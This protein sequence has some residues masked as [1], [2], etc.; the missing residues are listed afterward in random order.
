MYDILYVNGNR[1]SI[2]NELRMTV[3]RVFFFFFF[4]GL[5][6]NE[7]SFLF[8]KFEES[9]KYSRRIESKMKL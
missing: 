7:E 5:V 9:L 2:V 8:C 4:L 3:Y 1:V 6:E